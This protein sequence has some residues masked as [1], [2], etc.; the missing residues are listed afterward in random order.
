MDDL[1]REFAEARGE[2]FLEENERLQ[3]DPEAAVPE[4]VRQRA[5]ELI[6]GRE[7]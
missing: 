3:N 5:L 6:T 7:D 1:M 2:K 4:E